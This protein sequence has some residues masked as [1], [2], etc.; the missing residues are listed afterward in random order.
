M[1]LTGSSI[2]APVAQLD[3]ARLITELLSQRSQVRA[4]PGAPRLL[5]REG[6]V[7][8]DDQREGVGTRIANR[9][10]HEK[11]LTVG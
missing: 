3:R 4:L 5:S 11:A 9:I 7:P 10:N 8:A 1:R 2:D 6:L